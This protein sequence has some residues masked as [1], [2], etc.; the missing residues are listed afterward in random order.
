MDRGADR[1]VVV[2]VTD[3][4][5]W[6]V[7]RDGLRAGD[8]ETVNGVPDIAQMDVAERQGDLQSQRE[9]TFKLAL[10]HCITSNSS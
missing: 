2:R 4:S 10:N 6:R 7:R 3:G 8:G 5:L 9:P 1:A